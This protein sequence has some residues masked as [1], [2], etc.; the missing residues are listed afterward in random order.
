MK[1]VLAEHENLFHNNFNFSTFLLNIFHDCVVVRSLLYDELCSSFSCIA[2][3]S[4]MHTKRV[5]NFYVNVFLRL[6]SCSS[7]WHSLSVLI[8]KLRSSLLTK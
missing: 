8:I 1:H 5:K 3:A 2:K 6:L 7:I 4:S